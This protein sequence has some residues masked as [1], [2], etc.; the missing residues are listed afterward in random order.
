MNGSVFLDTPVLVRLFDDD[1]PERQAAVRAVIG[2]V[3]GEDSGPALVL[4]AQVLAEFVDVATTRLVRPLPAVTARR[5][6]A[7]LAE[8]HVVPLDADLVLAAADTAEEHGLS[9][10]D[11]LVVEAAASS[12]CSRLM[13]EAL[14]HGT[15]VRGVTVE[16]PGRPDSRP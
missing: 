5:A 12:G 3:P 4:S 1:E 13:T 7:D 10:R 2:V 9:I 16:D 14:P 6:L 11:A 8:L 15:M